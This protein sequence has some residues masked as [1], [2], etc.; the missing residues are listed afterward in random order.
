VN[1]PTVKVMQREDDDCMRACLAT[2]FGVPI[3]DVPV[4]RD[5]VWMKQVRDWVR[6]RGLGYVTVQMPSQAVF[7][8]AFSDGLVICGGPGVRSGVPHAVI[9]LDGKLWHDPHASGTGIQ[10]VEHVD[11]FYSL[12]PRSDS[13]R[14]TQQAALYGLI[15]AYNKLPAA[16]KDCAG[17]YECFDSRGRSF[18]D[19]ALAVVREA[20]E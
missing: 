3:E 9:Y 1:L 14:D 8:E 6:P 2:Y 10:G 4:L 12:A 11:F 19:A 16:S 7:K 18:F 13:T 20:I 5:G 17:G 15:D